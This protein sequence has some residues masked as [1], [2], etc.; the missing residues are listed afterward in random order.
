ML[1]IPRALVPAGFCP[2][3]EENVNNKLFSTLCLL[4]FSASFPCASR[5]EISP[6]ANTAAAQFR[7]DSEQFDFGRV[8]AGEQVEAEF[9]FTNTGAQTLEITGI[10]PGCGCT[11]KGPYDRIVPPGQR[12]RIVLH[13]NTTEM[14][15]FIRRQVMVTAKNT[16]PEKITLSLVGTVSPLAELAPAEII[17]GKLDREQLP[18]ARTV[19]FPPVPA[20]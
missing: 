17:F 4:A 16:W 18:A 20:L 3:P 2:F 8:W 1:G 19:L 7:F 15:G 10:K 12:G 14:S 6:A 5:G 13:L 9:H 11:Q